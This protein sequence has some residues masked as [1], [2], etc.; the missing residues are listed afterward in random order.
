MKQS[1]EIQWE[2]KEAEHDEVVGYKLYSSWKN[3]KARMHPV[4]RDYVSA[5]VNYFRLHEAE[6]PVLCWFH[7]NWTDIYIGQIIG[8]I[9][10]Q[11]VLQGCLKL[12]RGPLWDEQTI[13]LDRFIFHLSFI[14]KFMT[15]CMGFSN[16]LPCRHCTDLNLL[17]FRKEITVYEIMPDH[18]PE[19]ILQVNSI[20]RL[21]KEALGSHFLWMLEQT[22]ANH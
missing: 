12:W 3:Y 7:G 8:Q 17:T 13:W 4:N 1:S 18:A 15:P 10:K 6:N 19:L 20:T 11:A 14:V 16:H 2:K 22:T 9:L 5:S 21:Y